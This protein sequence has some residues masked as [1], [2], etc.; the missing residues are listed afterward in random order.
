MN[1]TTEDGWCTHKNHQRL[2]LI[3]HGL[4]ALRFSEFSDLTALGS[5]GV[6]GDHFHLPL[7]SKS[8]CEVEINTSKLGSEQ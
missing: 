3:L 5:H 8:L 4:R 2:R 7:M 1:A 6:L